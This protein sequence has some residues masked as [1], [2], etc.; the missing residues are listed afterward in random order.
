MSLDISTSL[1]NGPTKLDGTVTLDGALVCS[2]KWDIHDG[3]VACR[4]LGYPTVVYVKETEKS[5]SD[6]PGY[7]EFSCTGEE[8]SLYDCVHLQT[9]ATCRHKLAAVEC[10]PAERGTQHCTIV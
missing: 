4:E 5:D 2:N 3:Q 10:S 6:V 7:T 9:N 1:I 8:S